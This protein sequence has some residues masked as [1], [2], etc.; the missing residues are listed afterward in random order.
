MFS[1]LAL[2]QYGIIKLPEAV[3]FMNQLPIDIVFVNS[4]SVIIVIAIFSFIVNFIILN[5][6]KE[7][8]LVS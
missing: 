2:L 4:L 1:Y 6:F 8:T 5:I 3:Y 7:E